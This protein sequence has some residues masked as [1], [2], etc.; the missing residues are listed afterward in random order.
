MGIKME[1]SYAPRLHH[2]TLAWCVRRGHAFEI[3]ECVLQLQNLE[4]MT[5]PSRNSYL[6]SCLQL[7]GKIP[8]PAKCIKNVLLVTRLP[9]LLQMEHLVHIFR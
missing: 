1:I 6:V 5:K 8:D 7:L 9:K 2:E 3:E 4:S